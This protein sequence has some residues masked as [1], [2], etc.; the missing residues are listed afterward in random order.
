MILGVESG[1]VV[2]RCESRRAVVVSGWILQRR[3]VLEEKRKVRTWVRVRCALRAR[4]FFLS[5]GSAPFLIC[6]LDCYPPRGFSL[7]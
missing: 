1:L 2:C 5:S 6:G 7:R 3:W 4:C